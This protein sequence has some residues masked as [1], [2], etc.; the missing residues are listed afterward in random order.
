[1]A[2]PEFLLNVNFS[3]CKQQQVGYFQLFITAIALLSETDCV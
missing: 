2:K 1:M 3:L